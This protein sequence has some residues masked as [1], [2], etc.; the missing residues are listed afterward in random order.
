MTHPSATSPIRLPRHC[1][2]PSPDWEILAA[3]W[4]PV[5]RSADVTAAAPVAARLLDQD[6]VLYRT[7]EGITAAVDTCV[8]RGA[9]L[10]M[11][12]MRNGHLACAYHGYCYNAAGH[13]VT[14]PAHP[15][16]PIPAKLHLRTFPAQERYGLI[17]VCLTPSSPHE[18][19]PFPEAE[20]PGFQVI[21]IPPLHWKAS[22]GRQVESFCDVAHFA[23]VHE[24]TFATATPEVPRYSVDPT[25]Y[26]LHADFTS[27]VGNVSDPAAA[28]QV[29][30]RIY[31]IHLPFTAHLVIHFPGQ[32][33]MAL[34]NASCPVSARQTTI[35]AVVARE[36]DHDQ[37]VADLIAFQNRVYAE[38]Q[39]IVERQNPEELPVDLAEEVHVRADLTSVTY[40]RQLHR[41]GLG[42]TFT[43]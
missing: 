37:P 20:M 34:L 17:W 18:I 28:G 36:F 8:H 10:S 31:K 5:A 41:L 26:G 23:F 9:T 35:F 19:P 32:G 4:H 12:R 39:A 43:S 3:Y 33:R 22:A 13:C 1:T 7:A 11:G 27:N 2:F 16:L 21:Q 15:G 42:R 25:D 40:R 6:L 29:W 14:I 24:N 38:D 30:R